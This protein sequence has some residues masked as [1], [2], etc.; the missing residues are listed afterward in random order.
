MDFWV[1]NWGCGE[2]V[3]RKILDKFYGLMRWLGHE[4]F[5]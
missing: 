1:E 4:N 3:A 5:K 2:W